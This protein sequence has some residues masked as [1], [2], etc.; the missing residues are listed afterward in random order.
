MAT[1]IFRKHMIPLYEESRPPDLFLDG[2]FQVRPGNVSNT[3]KVSIDVKRRDERIAAVVTLGEGPN[4]SAAT[5][6]VTK[7]WTPPTIEEGVPFDAVELMKRQAGVNEYAASDVGFQAQLMA[8]VIEEFRELSAAIGRNR[9]WQASQ[10]LQTGALSLFDRDGNTFYTV[11]YLPETSHFPTT[12]NAWGGGSD[13]ILDDIESLADQIRT[14]HLE[15]PDRIILGHK[16]YNAFRNDTGIQAQLD[17]RRFRVG[18]IAPR[19]MGQ[20]AKMVGAIDVGSHQFEIWIYNG[21]GIKP[22]SA[23]KERYVDQ[24]SCIIMAS[25]GRLDK[26]FGGVPRPVDTDPRFAGMLPG[27]VA[28]PFAAMESPNIYATPNGRQTIIELA[29]RP[30]AVPTALDSFG[31]LDTLASTV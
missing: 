4:Y 14:D 30:L 11:N 25:G 16:A 23:T 24:D 10:V 13:T 18:E 9:E 1:E 3:E 15:E 29:S 20:G 19:P 17:N 12:A 31:C 28:V 7:E 8:R 21:Q 26:V 2:F 27:R 5:Q 6:F 22:G